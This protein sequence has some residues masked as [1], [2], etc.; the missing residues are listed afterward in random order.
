VRIEP[1]ASVKMLLQR[2]L[3]VD[4]VPFDPNR[5]AT[6]VVPHTG[7]NNRLSTIKIQPNPK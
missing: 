2:P 4:V 5:A 1:G 3:T 7:N 6:D